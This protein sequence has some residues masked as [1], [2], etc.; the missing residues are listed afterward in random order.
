MQSTS[1][2]ISTPMKVF[3]KC[4]QI[5]NITR[6][7]LS[8]VG[9]NQWLTGK[10]Y[11]VMTTGQWSTLKRQMLYM[12]V[13][14]NEHPMHVSVVTTDVR[15]R[16]L[17][18]SRDKIITVNSTIVMYE[19]DVDAY[20]RE[21]LKAYTN[22]HIQFLQSTMFGHM[23]GVGTRLV[24]PKIDW[25]PD[26]IGGSKWTDSHRSKPVRNVVFVN[27]ITHL[28]TTAQYG[29]TPLEQFGKHNVDGISFVYENYPETLTTVKYTSCS[30]L[31]AKR[32]KWIPCSEV[33]NDTPGAVEAGD[34]FPIDGVMHVVVHQEA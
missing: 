16:H 19:K 29:E 22:A 9:S 31:K 32:K 17:A 14:T 30:L 8:R 5:G 11:V 23:F 20:K 21:Q 15:A 12:P 26:P 25:V 28:P 7:L 1:H 2:Y 6:H 33:Y 3:G 27:C 24:Y 34:F 18:C 10:A 13:Q 4:H